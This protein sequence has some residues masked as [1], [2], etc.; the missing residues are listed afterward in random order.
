MTAIERCTSRIK[1]EFFAHYCP[2]VA[3][4]SLINGVNEISLFL[5][6]LIEQN[7]TKFWFY[8]DANQRTK[9]KLIQNK[10]KI[11]SVI[12]P[13]RAVQSTSRY[14]RTHLKCISKDLM[15]ITGH[16]TDAH[17]TTPYSIFAC[18][19]G[20]YIILKQ[21]FIIIEQILLTKIKQLPE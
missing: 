10:F 5:S 16:Q 2:T 4:I 11:N 13:V 6:S 12:W 14:V 15:L 20:Q 19:E 17:W 1:C 8:L 21:E 3:W 9:N 7:K 18:K